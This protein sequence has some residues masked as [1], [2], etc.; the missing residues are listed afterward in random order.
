MGKIGH[1][2]IIPDGGRR[3]AK[4]ENVSLRESYRKTVDLLRVGA[5]ALFG[6][7]VETLSLY[8]LSLENLRRTAGELEAILIEEK[9]LVEE[10]VPNLCSRLAVTPAVV[11]AV[12]LLPVPWNG[13]QLPPGV[14][15]PASGK[16]LYLCLTYSP[17]LELASAV[18]KIGG[19]TD[20]ASLWNAL[21]V[22]QPVDLLIRTG[23]AHTLSN[24]IPLQCGYAQLVFLDDLFNDT[25]VDTILHIVE[26]QVGRGYKY[27]W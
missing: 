14:N 25:T 3:W 24:F 1:V 9:R 5:E 16:K 6:A 26:Q 8:L 4:R 13:I 17:N 12:D 15:W 20:P 23:G 21:W 22:K 2:A 27:G 19:D 7:G 18:R 10:V 11:G